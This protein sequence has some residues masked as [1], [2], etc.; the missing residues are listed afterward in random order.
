[1]QASGDDVLGPNI[2]VVRHYQMQQ[3]GLGL[4][5]WTF[6]AACLQLGKLPF[7]PVRAEFAKNIELSPARGFRA[8]IRQ[9][10]DHTLFDPVDSGVRL[11]DKAPQTFGKPVITLGLTAVAVHAL[12]DHDPVSV[13]G[14]DEAM[15]IEVKPILDR[16]AINLGDKPARSGERRAIKTDPITDRDKLMWRLARVIA[17][18]A[19]NMDTELSR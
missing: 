16:R 19:T 1:M 13:I 17:A 10:D 6:G 8:P 9:V 2:V 11:V 18:P 15:E 12:L 4:R 14:D 5:A 7:D 3:H